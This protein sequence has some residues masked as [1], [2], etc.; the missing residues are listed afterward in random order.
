[1]T[2]SPAAEVFETVPLFAPDVYIKD[3][4]HSPDLITLPATEEEAPA[5]E[6]EAPV[7][8]NETETENAPTIIKEIAKPKKEEKKFSTEGFRP[9]FQ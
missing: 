2:L 9:L 6:E 5:T 8:E 7:T 4:R 3:F 1:M